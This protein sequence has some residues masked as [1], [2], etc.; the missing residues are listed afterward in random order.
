M[1]KETFLE[2][3]FQLTMDFFAPEKPRPDMEVELDD[4]VTDVKEIYKPEVIELDLKWQKKSFNTKSK[5]PIGLVLHYTWSGKTEQ[6]A[7]NVANYFSN[8]PKELG[9][10]LACPIMSESGKIYVAKGWNILKDCNNN[11]GKSSW[12][13]M[14]NLSDKF[15]GLETCSWGLLDSKTL[16]KVPEIEIRTSTKRDNIAAGRYQMFTEAQEKE[17]VE[18]CFYLKS[19]CPDFEFDN[20]VGHDECSGGRKFDPGASLSMTM[21]KFREHLKVLWKDLHG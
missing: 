7:K 15:L 12:R 3:L 20:V 19:V 4:Q 14:T 6:A 13:G 17:I 8:T 10:Q 18:L 11:A 5:M 16:K 1:T 2:K 21:P 9:Y